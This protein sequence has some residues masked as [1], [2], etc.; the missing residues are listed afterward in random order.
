VPEHGSA[1]PSCGSRH[2]RYDRD[3]DTAFCLG[4]GRPYDAYE[5]GEDEEDPLIA[6]AEHA[7]VCPECGRSFV[8][9]GFAYPTAERISAACG[10][11]DPRRRHARH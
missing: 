8:V 10:H 4:C 1:C 9:R 11:P 6:G 2:R 7:V 5:L 3:S